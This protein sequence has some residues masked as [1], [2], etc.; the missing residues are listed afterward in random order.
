MLELMKRVRRE[1]AKQSVSSRRRF[2][3]WLGFGAFTLSQQL[4]S[5]ALDK[6][7]A[8]LMESTESNPGPPTHWTPA[9]NSDLIWFQRE[10][11]VDGTWRITGV[12]T[13]IDRHSGQVLP[14]IEGQ[15]DINL[16]PESMRKA[17]MS[18]SH[19]QKVKPTPKAGSS[20]TLANAEDASAQLHPVGK[21][22][23]NSK[24]YDAGP[25]IIGETP[26][27]LGRRSLTY[28]APLVHS[29]DPVPVP[30]E[31][32]QKS[33]GS[34]F[35]G[36][37]EFQSTQPMITQSVVRQQEIVFPV[38]PSVPDS[39]TPGKP[40]PVVRAREGL[41]PSRWLRKLNANEIRRWLKTI[42]VPE[43]GVSGMTYWTHLTEHHLFD[44]ERIKGLSESDLAK[45]HAAAHFGY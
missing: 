14:R 5:P 35:E 9:G 30:I 8:K 31:A 2:A 40:D 7:A 25:H 27:R 21:P 39:N 22:H 42:K 44:A 11:L 1:S 41:P 37:A 13:P 28:P 18:S 6:L 10:T 38:D 17:A 15:I 29:S 4:R 36:P 16:V 23:V 34:N 26:E 3:F 45:L 12:S 33:D 20:K 24:P 19:K 32:L 43:V